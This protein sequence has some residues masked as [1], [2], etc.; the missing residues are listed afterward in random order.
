MYV[1]AVHRA[2]TV[3]LLGGI[4]AASSGVQPANVYPSR[5]GTGG[6]TVVPKSCVHAGIS[7]PPA[8]S[9]VTVK[10]STFQTALTVRLR[11]G[12]VAGSAGDHRSKV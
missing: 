4:V 5:V 6:F 11:G 1:F 3:T 12:I 8:A 9:N 2:V 7:A 10:A